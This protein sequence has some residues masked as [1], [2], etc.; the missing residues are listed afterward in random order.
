M[1][2]DKVYYYAIFPNLLLSLHP[3]YMMTHTLMAACCG[4]H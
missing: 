3:D 2:A 1:S 4:S